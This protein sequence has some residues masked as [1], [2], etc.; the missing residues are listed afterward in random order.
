MLHSSFF[1]KHRRE[2]ENEY[3]KI[4]EHGMKGDEKSEQLTNCLVITQIQ[5]QVQDREFIELLGK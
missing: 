2:Y 3:D 4:N 1:V 5:L